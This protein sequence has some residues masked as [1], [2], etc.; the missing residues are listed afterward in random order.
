MTKLALAL[1][2]PA[3]AL[4]ACETTGTTGNAAASEKEEDPRIGDRVDRMCFTG[5]ISGFSNNRKN[6]VVL[7]AGASREYYVE[8]TACFAMDDAMAIGIDPRAGSCLTRGDRLVVSDSMFARD[9]DN[10]NTQRCLI[11]AIYEWNDDAEKTG[12]GEEMTD[13]EEVVDATE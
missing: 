4:A 5:S 6:S 11:T 7:R 13:A 9:R 10:L 2:L 12:E 3:I 8:T 1:I